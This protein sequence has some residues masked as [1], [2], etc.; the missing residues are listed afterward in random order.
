[1]D[2]RELLDSLR[3]ETARGELKFPTSAEVG[4]RIRRL[5]ADPD[6]PVEKVA[7]LVQAEPLLAARVVGVANSAAYNRTTRPVTDVKVAVNRLGFR[8]VQALAAAL[9]TRQMSARC[10]Q[11]EHR[12]FAAQLWEH[13]VH[14]SALAHV[15]A[16]SVTRQDPEAA[17]FAGIVHE[18][19]GFYVLSRAAAPG[20]LDEAM[21]RWC[22]DGSPVE[23]GAEA[24]GPSA[25]LESEIGRAI[26][27]ALEVPAPVRT[28]IE[29]L[30]LGYMNIPPASLGDTLLLAD[31][32]APVR[33][34]F[35]QPVGEP[36][37]ETSKIIDLA[38]GDEQLSDLLR[39][40]EAEVRS[41]CEALGAGMP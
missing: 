17:M 10:A 28:G 8:M 36:N 33:S 6:C 4:T 25:T 37:R 30:W 34:P 29:A 13:T 26:L 11:P 7:R 24:Q 18:I 27:A 12:R 16:R 3:A 22:D 19:G 35:A 14:V 23:E 1:V 40:S 41:L 21:A 2:A 39:Q 5:I 20:L 15:C 32:L 38:V 31:Y 9:M